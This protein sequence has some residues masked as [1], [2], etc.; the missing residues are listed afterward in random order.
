[1]ACGSTPDVG[2]PPWRARGS[3]LGSATVLVLL[4]AEFDKW[5][6]TAKEELILYLVKALNRDN[7]KDVYYHK[8]ASG[9]RQN[10]IERKKQKNDI[11]CNSCGRWHWEERRER[12][13]EGREQLTRSDTGKRG[14]LIA[15]LAKSTGRK[16]QERLVPSV[17]AL[18]CS[19]WVPMCSPPPPLSRAAACHGSLHRNRMISPHLL[20]NTGHCG[21]HAKA[22]PF[23]LDRDH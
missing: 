2:S 18:C 10:P 1:M 6:Q 9:N 15:Q 17:S 23:V 11:S 13:A 19:W 4:V 16:Q 20:V 22:G 5:R 7:K 14:D 21:S 3:I 8:L 12:P